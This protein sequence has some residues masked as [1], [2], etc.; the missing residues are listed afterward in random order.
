MKG[1][2]QLGFAWFACLLIFTAW[3]ALCAGPQDIPVLKGPYL[4][5]K[6][7]GL[8]PEL[9]APGIVNT[10][11]YTRDVAMTPDGKEIYF[12]V[13]VGG[14]WNTILMVREVNG[15]W[16][17]PQVAPHMEDPNVLNFEPCIS[18]DGKKFYF[19]STRPD[20]SKNEKEGDQDIWAMD[21]QADGWGEPYNLGSPVDTDLAE[22]FPSVTRDGT[23][24][25]TRAEKDGRTNFIYRARWKD[26]R[27]LEPEK[28][29]PQVNC[30]TSQFN[31]FIA[32][33]E[34][35]IIVPVFGRKDGLGGTD[36]Y[37]VFRNPDDTWSEPVNMGNKINT[38]GGAEFS[39]YVSPNGKY[40]FFMSSRFLSREKWP[41]KLSYAD[42]RNA[43]LGMPNGSSAIYWVD[44]R[45]IQSLRPGRPGITFAVCVWHEAQI[46]EALALVES[47]RSFAGNLSRA[48]IRLYALEEI[49]GRDPALSKKCEALSVALFTFQAPPEYLA[50]PFAAKIIAAAR[51]E[52][53]LA[54]KT[55]VLAWLDPDTVV[56][57]EPNDFLLEKNLA[58]GY[59]PVMHQL[60][61][62]SFDQPP[63]EYWSRVYQLLGVKAESLFS[64][65]TPVD[66]KAIRP[67]FNAGLLVVRPERGV[68]RKW[69]EAFEAVSSDKALMD[70][71]RQDQRRMI[72]LHQAA[73]AG[74]VLV[75]L[76]R[77]EMSEL[78]EVYNYP[79]NLHDQIPADRR[80][81]T[82]DGL[83]TL[84][85]DEGEKVAGLLEQ[86]GLNGTRVDWL[87]VHFPAPAR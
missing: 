67:Y 12:C 73:L 24:Y 45:V 5:Q 31:A 79:L 41:A 59:R 13:S 10:G 39:P 81:T 60:I 77:E 49:A 54:G 27:F 30:G 23:L 19:L 52:G 11:M 87:R 76:R 83:A 63:D 20:T 75:G 26:G 64:M 40:F 51:A 35:Y 29:P 70:M 42:L 34:S 82:L 71:C 57:R 7:P 56:W 1:K 28:L 9:F 48:P 84:R 74:A 2:F 53:E 62:S 69:L 17:E 66:R 15:R 36:Y 14:N 78:P 61:G 4:G 47:I 65:V 43:F 21:R 86:S 8:E 80:L 68:L 18:P 50:I 22:Y 6:P 33:D 44:A 85:Y 46:A 25:F 72:F 37:V 38:P 3:S 58:L 16:M 32:P 55:E